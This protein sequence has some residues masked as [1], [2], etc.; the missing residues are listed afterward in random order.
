VLP[1]HDPRRYWLHARQELLPG[2]GEG[3]REAAERYN[4]ATR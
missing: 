2:R 3:L 4:A 1:G